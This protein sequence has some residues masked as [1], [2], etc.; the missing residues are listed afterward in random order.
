MY[1]IKEG[2]TIY[3]VAAEF[4]KISDKLTLS[5]S[6]VAEIS[7]QI[8]E[9]DVEY[10]DRDETDHQQFVYV[11]YI[12]LAEIIAELEVD[13]FVKTKNKI[14]KKILSFMEGISTLVTPDSAAAS[15]FAVTPPTGNTCPLTLN[16]PVRAIV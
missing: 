4:E 8:E 3:L 10:T 7:E 1:D 15:I 16:E 14:S 9:N 13:G 2:A 11:A 5:S 12:N 6:G